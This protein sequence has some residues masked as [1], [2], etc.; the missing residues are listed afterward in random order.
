[1]RV[2]G[3]AGTVPCSI[4]SR[5]APVDDVRH[6]HSPSTHCNWLFHPG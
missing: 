6:Y 1:M 2:R 4:R 3:N 5:V